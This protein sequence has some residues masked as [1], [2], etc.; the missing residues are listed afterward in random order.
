MTITSNL[1]YKSLFFFISMS[2]IEGGEALENYIKNPLDKLIFFPIKRRKCKFSQFIRLS[3]NIDR[4]IL[5]AHFSKTEGL[6]NFC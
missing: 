1:T 6:I 3:E 2:A 5:S 4:C